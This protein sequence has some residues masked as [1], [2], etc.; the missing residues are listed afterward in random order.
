MCELGVSCV[1]GVPF[2]TRVS[3]ASV[4]QDLKKTMA[5]MKNDKGA[6]VKDAQAK[7]KAA[8]KAQEAAHKIHSEH[9]QVL[10]GKLAEQENAETQRGELQ[11]QLEEAN[12][13][14]K[15]AAV[16]YIL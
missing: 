4:V 13:E 15:K 9:D 16:C 7:L 12:T 5:L 6:V 11:E 8:K 3:T 2:E 10:Q 14:E 1:R